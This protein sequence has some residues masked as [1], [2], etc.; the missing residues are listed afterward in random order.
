MKKPA[1]KRRK[2]IK[3]PPPADLRN[4]LEIALMREWNSINDNP[5]PHVRVTRVANT[6]IE[7][8]SKIAGLSQ[9]FSWPHTEA[10][11]AAR[12]SG[13][14]MIKPKGFLMVDLVQLTWDMA[15]PER[16]QWEK[17]GAEAQE[18]WRRVFGIFENLLLK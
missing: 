7:A 9:T 10:K 16:R 8:L 11:L 3:P 4:V 1:K 13:T 12:L 17:I 6:V 18:E 14:A 2:V 5:Y 15:Y